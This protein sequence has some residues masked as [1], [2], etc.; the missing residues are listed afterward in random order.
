MYVPLWYFPLQTRLCSLQEAIYSAIIQ[1]LSILYIA[2]SDMYIHSK[3]GSVQVVSFPM[4]F[5]PF[6]PYSCPDITQHRCEQALFFWNFPKHDFLFKKSEEIW[7]NMSIFEKMQNF[8]KMRFCLLRNGR[9][10]ALTPQTCTQT[11]LFCREHGPVC[12]LTQFII[13]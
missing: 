13:A 4:P 2:C 12:S 3:N 10:W 9:D 11:L 8:Q 6:L 5:L 1:E 7:K